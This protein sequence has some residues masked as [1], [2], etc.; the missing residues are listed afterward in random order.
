M[1]DDL[2]LSRTQSYFALLQ[3]LRIYRQWIKTT[4]RDVDKWYEDG[5]EW[6]QLDHV[7]WK[8]SDLQRDRLVQFWGE[9]ANAMKSELEPVLERISQKEEETVT[10]RDGV[11]FC[12]IRFSGRHWLTGLQLFTATAIRE[13][14]QGTLLN[15]YVFVFTVVTVIYLPLTFVTVRERPLSELW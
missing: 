14:R 2:S 11:G 1:Y 15:R 4:L 8:T 12:S 3:H 5:R 6:L 9:T 13:A 7:G 10:L